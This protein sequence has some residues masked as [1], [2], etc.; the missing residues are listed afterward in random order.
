[1]MEERKS[2]GGGGAD[3]VTVLRGHTSPV[4]SLLVV[5]GDLLLSGSDAGVIKLWSV[6]SGREVTKELKAHEHSIQSISKLDKSSIVSS[7]RDGMAVVWDLQSNELAPYFSIFTECTH[8]CN[9]ATIINTDEQTNLICCP[10]NEEQIVM[11][12]IRESSA[13]TAAM[14]FDARPLNIKTGMTMSLMYR[15]TQNNSAHHVISGYES[16]HILAFDVRASKYVNTLSTHKCIGC[17][18]QM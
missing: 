15:A 8:F 6:E 7:G 13:H 12:D 9:S 11:W 18:W 4:T 10:S 17:N 3:P 2:I 16:G 5:D 1:M 14:T